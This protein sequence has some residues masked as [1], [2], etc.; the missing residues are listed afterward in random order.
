M[1]KSPPWKILLYAALIFIGGLLSG[2]V[3]G[4]VLRHTFLGPWSSAVISDHMLS[5][6][7]S[8]LH[9]TPDQMAQIKPFVEKAATDFYAIRSDTATEVSN[10]MK[11]AN[12]QIAQFLTPQQKA[13][14]QKMESE[15]RERLVRR[16]R[17]ASP[18]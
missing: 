4:P 12:S 11:E 16:L 10:R 18:P 13:E 7:K 15:H 5:R 14:L 3:L 2:L 1:S 9:L 8:R 6:L 17:T